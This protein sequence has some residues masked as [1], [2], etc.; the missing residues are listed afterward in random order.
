MLLRVRRAAELGVLGAM[1]NMAS[2]RDETGALVVHCTCGRAFSGFPLR[3]T[4]EA[5][6]AAAAAAMSTA[7][8]TTVEGYTTARMRDAGASSVRLRLP[9]VT[10]GG[11]S[12]LEACCVVSLRA[13]GRVGFMSGL[14]V[15]RR[16]EGTTVALEVIVLARCDERFQEVTQLEDDVLRQLLPEGSTVDARFLLPLCGLEGP[17]LQDVDRKGA[18]AAVDDDSDNDG[19]RGRWLSD[20]LLS[21]AAQ[22]ESHFGAA[23]DTHDVLLHETGRES[24]EAWLLDAGLY[25]DCGFS[26]LSAP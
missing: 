20:K 18:S 17:L 11:E 10:L 19:D 21:F 2:A 5:A 14:A 15:P 16:E 8:A 6:R 4:T 23:R 12:F 24:I 13:Q 3:V 9:V 7:M 25:V 22:F 1:G 26:A